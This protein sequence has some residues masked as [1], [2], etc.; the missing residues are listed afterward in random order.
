MGLS[1]TRFH[2]ATIVL[3]VHQVPCVSTNLILTLCAGTFTDIPRS[4]DQRHPQGASPIRPLDPPEDATIGL[5]RALG[6]PEGATRL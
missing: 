2:Y 4:S 6:P 5:V 3:Q 1:W